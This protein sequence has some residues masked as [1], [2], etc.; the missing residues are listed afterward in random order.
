M[1]T[2]MM[3]AAAVLTLG[4]SAQA[5]ESIT[6]TST[7]YPQGMGSK[8]KIDFQDGQ[9]SEVHMTLNDKMPA[10]LAT[11]GFFHPH[12]AV[13]ENHTEVIYLSWFA[14]AYTNAAYKNLIPNKLVFYSFDHFLGNKQVA[15]GIIQYNAESKTETFFTY[16]CQ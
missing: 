13:D 1:K 16:I 3:V 12:F 5:Q 9:V 14:G 8:L 10:G 2:M 7:Q 15:A 6:C 4:L 11:Q